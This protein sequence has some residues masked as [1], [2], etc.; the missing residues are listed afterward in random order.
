MKAMRGHQLKNEKKK[1]VSSENQNCE[2]IDFNIFFGI[3]NCPDP[4]TWFYPSQ[5]SLFAPFALL[6]VTHSLLNSSN[7]H[8]CLKRTFLTDAFHINCIK[9]FFQSSSQ[10]GV[11]SCKSTSWCRYLIWHWIFYAGCP[12]WCSPP[13]PHLPRQ[14]GEH[15][16]VHPRWLGSLFS[17]LS[18]TPCIF[19]TIYPVISNIFIRFPSVWN[20]TAH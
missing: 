13:P 17:V 19:L 5:T 14:L 11:H 2:M 18:R 4:I 15:W 10:Q 1:Y 12:T 8:D 16:L 9:F 3:S 7:G 20:M 6:S